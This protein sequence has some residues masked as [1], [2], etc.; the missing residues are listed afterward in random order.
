MD[1]QV[2]ICRRSKK[3]A[4]KRFCMAKGPGMHC[5]DKH[6]MGIYCDPCADIAAC[7]SYSMDDVFG[8]LCVEEFKAVCV[9]D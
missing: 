8:S 9:D 6:G 4:I 2:F 3:I 1:T 5:R 7:R